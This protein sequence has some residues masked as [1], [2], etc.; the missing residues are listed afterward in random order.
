MEQSLQL[1]IHQVTC[2]ETNHL[3]ITHRPKVVCLDLNLLKVIRQHQ[4][5]YSGLN[6]QVELYLE[7]SLRK[8]QRQVLE[9]CLEEINLQLDLF[10][11]VMLH[12]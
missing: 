10:S 12:Q 4:G 7:V 2:S 11:V 8:P 5:A 6:L 3:K 1:A 9:A